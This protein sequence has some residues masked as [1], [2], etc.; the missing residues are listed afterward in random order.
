[1]VYKVIQF[2]AQGNFPSPEKLLELKKQGVTHL[3]NVSGIDLFTLYSAEK[4]A[5]FTIVQFTFKDVFS[6]ALAISA[7]QISNVD[8]NVYC[9]HST[10]A[11]RAQFFNA[12]EQL[13]EWL[14]SEAQCYVFCHQGIGRSACVV[15]AALNHYYQPK[16]DCLLK[17]IKFLNPR[18]TLSV[19]SFAAAK[20]FEQQA[21]IH[22]E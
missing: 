12:V 20:W 10:E 18:A 16:H 5:D 2:L 13:I 11:E 9:E 1:M 15:L 19:T 17:T 8:S 22:N 14:K 4:L 21:A 6:T 3:L 7:E